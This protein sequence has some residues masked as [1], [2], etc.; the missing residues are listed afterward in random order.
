MSEH[1]LNSETIRRSFSRLECAS[2]CASNF[3]MSE[4]RDG[5]DIPLKLLNK[6]FRLKTFYRPPKDDARNKLTKCDVF[7]FR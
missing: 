3:S 5:K 4:K 1:F 6:Q 7:F 2:N